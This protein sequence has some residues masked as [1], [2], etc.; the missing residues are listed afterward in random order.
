MIQDL[1]FLLIAVFAVFLFCIIEGYNKGFL[2][3]IVSLVGTVLI[4]AAVI[5]VSPYVSDVLINKTSAYDAVKIKMVDVFKDDNSKLDNTD[6]MNQQLTIESYSVPDILKNALIQNNNA[7]VYKDLMV[8]IFEDYVS[9]YLARLIIKGLTF[10]GIYLI[11]KIVL[12]LIMKSVDLISKIPVI[13]GFNKF[14]GLIAGFV[15]ALIIVWI[16]FIV[17]VV[18][19]GNDIGEKLMEEVYRSPILTFLFNENVLMKFIT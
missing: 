19:L 12:W 15:N 6:P 5:F 18:F 10:V 16:F 4:I 7:E 13:K 17:V 1:N 2:K 8:S 3:I 11:L 14:L 9:G